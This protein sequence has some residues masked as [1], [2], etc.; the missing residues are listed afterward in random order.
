MSW[1][2][3][4]TSSTTKQPRTLSGVLSLKFTDDEKQ[5]EKSVCI[6]LCV[7]SP[8]KKKHRFNVKVCYDGLKMICVRVCVCSR[9]QMLNNFSK[10]AEVMV[11][12]RCQQAA[13]IDAK[14]L[15][16]LAAV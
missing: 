10:S 2:L 14:V 12:L 16:F 8:L 5:L 3:A 6:Y 11:P 1:E 13:E 7:I 15:E 9:V 4:Y